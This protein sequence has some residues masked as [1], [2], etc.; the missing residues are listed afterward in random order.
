[1]VFSFSFLFL[2][3]ANIYPWLRGGR[4]SAA[5]IKRAVAGAKRLPALSCTCGGRTCLWLKQSR[6]LTL[7]S[8]LEERKPGLAFASHR[9]A[10]LVLL[11]SSFFC[12]NQTKPN[13]VL[14]PGLGQFG[15]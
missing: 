9:L 4:S 6:A 1:M 14:V 12:S 11:S 5:E 2:I 8:T 15:L 7:M 13:S 10:A 3:F